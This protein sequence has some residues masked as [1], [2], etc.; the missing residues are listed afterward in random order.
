MVTDEDQQTVWQADY[1]PF[2]K[3]RIKT[4][5]ITLNLRF[6]G[7]YEDS[8][9]GT[10]YN[11]FRDYN[12][13]RGRYQT[14]DPIGLKGG[15]NS[16]AYVSGDPLGYS[17]PLGLVIN[18]CIPG[19]CRGITSF[20]DRSSAY[21]LD[22]QEVQVGVDSVPKP[23]VNSEFMQ[24]VSAVFA[25][26]AFQL[27]NNPDYAGNNALAAFAKALKDDAPYIVGGLLGISAL[28]AIPPPVGISL[29]G[30]VIALGAVMVG[31]EGIVFLREVADLLRTV[32][33]IP[34]C[35]GIAL[36]QQG[37]EFANT[38]FKTG[39]NVAEGAILGS[40]GAIGKVAK[41]VKGFDKQPKGDSFDEL[42]DDVKRN[43][44]VNS[45]PGPVLPDKIADTFKNGI[46]TNRILV[47]DAAFYKYHGVDNRTGKKYSWLTNKRYASE[48]E[49]RTDLAIRSDWGVN[50]TSVSEFKVPKGTWVSEGSA[51]SQG[52]GYNGGGYQA[53]ITNL[54]KSWVV[55]TDK[56]FDY[57]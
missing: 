32:S 55:R 9:T 50:I 49:L 47:N 12:P 21:D 17:D 53:V 41:Y 57:E 44:D 25:E 30:G 31:V 1:S 20:I 40:F 10:Y 52:E 34:G 22:Q 42:V 48:V 7:Q 35:D 27:E 4:E 28:S 24:K 36:Q 54:P 38:I 16:Y 2:G 45:L 14:S 26:A 29:T 37:S 3:A 56:A 6:A 23:S 19:P 39:L 11:Y 33:T 43:V 5:Q 18:I 51:A 13:N 8:E 46:Y 15:V